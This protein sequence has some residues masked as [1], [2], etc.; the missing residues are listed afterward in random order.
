MPFIYTL[1]YIYNIYTH[2]TFQNL[3]WGGDWKPH[4]SSY[5]WRLK[6][7]EWNFDHTLTLP[8]AKQKRMDEIWLN[9]HIQPKSLKWGHNLLHCPRSTVLA[10]IMTVPTSTVAEAKVLMG[11]GPHTPTKQQVQLRKFQFLSNPRQEATR[12]ISTAWKAKVHPC[13]LVMEAVSPLEN[14]I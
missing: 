14:P 3:L 9:V 4:L 6:R 7:S 5:S 1:Q 2:I 13:L 10:G 11:L 8:K 12:W